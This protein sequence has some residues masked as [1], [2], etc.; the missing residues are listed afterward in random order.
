MHTRNIFKLNLEV[1][2]INCYHGYIS[3]RLER[4]ANFCYCTINV[5]LF[6]LAY[7]EGKKGSKK[8]VLFTIVK[9]L[10]FLDGPFNNAF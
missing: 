3:N 1:Y 10:T 9:M 2:N 6:T 7:I 8:S 4:R 5:D